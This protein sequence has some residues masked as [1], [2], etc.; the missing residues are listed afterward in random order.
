MHLGEED[1]VHLSA[2][3]FLGDCS[4]ARLCMSRNPETGEQDGP[5]VVVG[6]T[7]YSLEAAAALGTAIIDI[8]RVGLA[9]A[10]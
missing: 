3:L 5:V 4:D 7:E 9:T 8:T 6:S 10:S 1:W 2:P